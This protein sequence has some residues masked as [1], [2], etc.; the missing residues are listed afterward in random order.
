MSA[1]GH[2]RPLGIGVVGLG[3][4]GPNLVRNLHD[5]ADAEV[6]WICDLRSEL[7][8]SVGRRYPAVE[9][10][11]RFDELLTD[12]A[13]DAVAIATPVSTHYE[14]ASAAHDWTP[15]EAQLYP[16]DAAGGV[17]LAEVEEWNPPVPMG[18]VLSKL[19]RAGGARADFE[20]GIVR[21]T[22]NEYETALAAA[23]GR[24]SSTG[25]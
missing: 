6:R 25:S 3:Y 2:G 24:A 16:G 21:I 22:A 18:I 5:V 1:N 8:E 13:V 23:A 11:Q 4:W 19:D 7:L 14:L 17:L 20:T 10:T 12:P 15:S 9:R